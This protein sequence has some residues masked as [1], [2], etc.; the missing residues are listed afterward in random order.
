MDD[1]CE[2][3]ERSREAG[4]SYCVDCGRPVTAVRGPA[5]GPREKNATLTT[6]VRVVGLIILLSCVAMLFFEIYAVFWTMD[7]ISAGMGG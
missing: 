7:G 4:H 2:Y 6:A 1:A 3:C 5:E